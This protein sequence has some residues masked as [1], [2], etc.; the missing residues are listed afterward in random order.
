M[1]QTLITVSFLL[2]FVF[3]FGQSFEGEIVYSATYKSKLANLSDQQI[4]S[5]IGGTQNYYIK[6]GD[7]KAETN[8][9]LMNWQLYIN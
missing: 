4:A 5:M 9:T 8:G 1:K 2:S 7:Y 6:G 3:S